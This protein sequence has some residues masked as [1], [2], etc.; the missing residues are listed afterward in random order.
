MLYAHHQA[1][2]PWHNQLHLHLRFR[3]DWRHRFEI[4]EIIF[5]I[6]GIDYRRFVDGERRAPNEEVGGTPGFEEFLNAMA[7][8]RHPERASTVEWYGGVFNP[9][10]ISPDEINVA[11]R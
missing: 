6:L 3:D 4:E 2:R 5:A 8:P 10:D 11:I 1:R 9:A 7:Q